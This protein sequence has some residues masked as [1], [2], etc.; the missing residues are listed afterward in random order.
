MATTTAKRKTSAHSSD[1]HEIIN[2]KI[3]EL[4]RKGIVPWRTSWAS[5][6][7]P[8]NLVS[9]RAYRG[10]NVLLLA[11]LGYEQNVFLTSRQLKEIDGAIKPEEKPHLVMYWSFGGKDADNDKQAEPEKKK[12]PQL[13]YYTVFNVAQCVGIPAEMVPAPMPETAPV[14][15]S[16]RIVMGILQ[17]PEIQHKEPGA[18]YDCLEDYVNMPKMKSFGKP[19]LYYSALFHQL[20]HSTG[21]HTRLDR[22]GVVQMPEFGYPKFTQEELTA[23]IG[24]CFLQSLVGIT[25][26]PETSISYIDTW[27]DMLKKDRFLVMNASSQAQKAVD[28]ILNIKGEDKEQS[29]E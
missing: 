18:Y 24:A 17:G 13:R 3:I 27:L 1:V 11:A 14:K 8:R 23:E 26:R 15:S 28:F 7:M 2:A 20:V 19:E 6:G 25:E 9:K 4:L 22:P 29:E 10:I 21:H 5:A 16:E 12:G